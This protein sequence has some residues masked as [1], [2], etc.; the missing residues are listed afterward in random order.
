M[1]ADFQVSY[2]IARRT[3]LV[4]SYLGSFSVCLIPKL[5]RIKP[6]LFSAKVPLYKPLQLVQM[7]RDADPI[8][9]PKVTAA[10]TA[11]S[12]VATPDL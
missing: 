9:E 2:S 5:R 6:Q 12:K 3:A 7:I 8:M 11:K 1:L 4:T 10:S